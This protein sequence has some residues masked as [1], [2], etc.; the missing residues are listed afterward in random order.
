MMC[1]KCG[2]VMQFEAS[3]FVDGDNAGGKDADGGGG[4]D[5]PAC[6]RCLECGHVEE[7]FNDDEQDPGD[8]SLGLNGESDGS[9]TGEW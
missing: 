5:H 8:S 2:D 3:G 9:D 1:P 7:M 6:W 4:R